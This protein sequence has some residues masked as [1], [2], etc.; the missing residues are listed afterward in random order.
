MLS[1]DLDN[2]TVNTTDVSLQEHQQGLLKESFT[3]TYVV[4]VGNYELQSSNATKIEAD[5]SGVTTTGRMKT[6]SGALGGTGLETQLN[7]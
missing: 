2:V 7:S 3:R 1:D 4:N 5:S 6:N